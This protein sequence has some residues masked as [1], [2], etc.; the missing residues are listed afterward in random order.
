MTVKVACGIVLALAVIS[1]GGMANAEG[2]RYPCAPSLEDGFRNPPETAAL[3]CWWH[4][5]D[6]CVTREG[7]TRDLEAMADAGISTAHIF[8]PK[9][10]DLPATAPVMSS[11]WIDLFAF[12]IKEAKRTGVKLGFHNCPGWSS[13]GGPW[14][15]PENSMKNVVASAMDV[16]LSAL[17]QDGEIKLP[18]PIS[19]CGFYRDLMTFAF[20]VKKQPKIKSGKVP[21]V[22]P[23]LK[24]DQ[25]TYELEYAEASSPTTAAL[26]V[27]TPNFYM[28]VSVEA[29]VDGRW[30]PRGERSFKCFKANENIKAI[31]LAKGPP[32]ARWRFVFRHLKAPPWVWRK[33]IPIR[34][35]ELG[36]WPFAESGC[37]SISQK[38]IVR[39][40]K[41]A[42]EVSVRTLKKQLSAQRSDS[43]R[44]VRIG[45]TTT[46][47]G[48][49]PASVRGLECD[50]LSRH[51]IE[52]HWGAMPAKLL[53]LPGAKDVVK[54]VV[55][56]SY[57]VGGQNWTQDLPVEFRRR[58]GRALGNFL[59]A[60]VGYS[61]GSPRETEAFNADL[62]DVLR[63]LFA[64]NYFDRFCA[65]CHEAGVQAVLEPYWGPFDI[66]R[67]SRDGDVLTGEF[68]I[69]RPLDDNLRP[70]V[71]AARHHGKNLIAAEAFTTEAKEGRWQ[72]TP[73]QL[74]RVGDAA[75][76]RGVNQFVLHSY[77]HQPYVDRRPGTSLQRH[78]TQLNVNTTWWPEMHVWTDYVKR[79]QF[80]LQYG[81]I[82]RDCHELAGGRLEALVRRGRGGE[83][84][85]FVRN[86]TKEPF[87]GM[88]KLDGRPGCVFD[89]VT[90]LIHPAETR[91][92]ETHVRFRPEESA[93]FV[94]GTETKT[95][96]R[97][98]AGEIVADLSKDWRIVSFDG[99]DAPTAPIQMD[100]LTSWHLS[101]NAQL[102]YFSGRA[103]YLK[104]G[105]FP[106]GMLDLGD[107]RE[108]AVVSVDGRRIGTLW[109]KPYQ[110][111][112]PAGHRIEVEVIN[113]WPNRLIGDAIRVRNG[114]CPFTWSN[115]NGGWTADDALRPAGLLGPVSLKSV[116]DS[117]ADWKLE[118]FARRN[119]NLLEVN[120]PKGESG[121]SA[122]RK[123]DLSRL[124][125]EVEF[126]IR[127]RGE[128]VTKP[129]KKW[130]GSKFML[131][132]VDAEGKH[133]WPGAAQKSGTF[134]WCELRFVCDFGTRVI[135]RTGELT[136]GLQSASGKIVFDLDSFRIIKRDRRLWQRSIAEVG[137]KCPY[138]STVSEKPRKR[139][140]MLPSGFCKED[141]FRTL[142][143]WGATLVRYQ[144]CR[145]WSKEGDNC[146]L[147][148]YDRWLD[149]KLNHLD[150]EVLPWAEKYGFEVAVDLHVA[151]GGRTGG[152][153]NMFY[154]KAYGDHFIACWQKIARR[155]KGRKNIYGYDLIN[156]PNQQFTGVTD[157]DCWNLQRRA[158]EAVR[159]I[160]PTVTI[161]LE[162]NGWDSPKAYSYMRPLRMTNVVY[163]AHMYEPSQFTHQ[164]VS[165]RNH[166]VKARYP[167]ETKGW[168][169][170]YLRR[171][172]EEVR[173]FQ[174]D[175]NAKIYIGEFSAIAWAEGADTYLRD[176]ISLFEEYG[177]DW[178]YHAFR[179]WDGWS[180]EHEG[181][182]M[183][184]LTPSGD[185]PRRQALIDGLHSGAINLVTHHE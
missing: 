136:F 171:Q 183:D 160:D 61:V 66:T 98:Q 146:D 13:S 142:R 33:D 31:S 14:I 172:L 29:F 84:I 153:M 137:Y 47:A 37:G 118:R 167:D 62:R 134:D 4:W 122:M 129:E 90:G 65:L 70:V 106:S 56:D 38:D 41:G 68:W 147:A 100:A 78:G 105:N 71:E 102:R 110:I 126:S 24:N 107:V 116:V 155:F 21:S 101:D 1:P 53:S 26:D 164:G 27:A 138:S 152:E 64:E 87:D 121:C 144:M 130:L 49:S 114:E 103:R 120:V 17:P 45:Y 182:D 149:A 42:S 128:N 143:E 44:I 20:P 51:G 92:E 36:D 19:K 34:C 173:K 99:L 168:D 148:E 170:D 157:G 52:A 127:C 55:I 9:M 43:W 22:V 151:P 175:H 3:Q 25:L 123:I 159:A 12:A 79:G 97:Q 82:E 176:C 89:A 6:D 58:K 109:Q 32:A 177:W 46:G 104:E 16:E 145:N 117:E 11:A 57:E 140:V 181:P 135:G 115:W 73:D 161:I 80:L 85:V 15:T 165:G 96:S 75:W 39:I 184:H 185:N 81:T 131:H 7:I 69:G 158:A 67:C 23:L 77:L 48:P 5:I 94:F 141:D 124:S 108:L 86:R 30:I 91:G 113:T 132:Y 179:E 166:W 60:M 54:F 119:G 162:S 50:K 74:R 72:I 59:L 28:T 8:A 133:Q 83:R 180:V 93:F 112:V 10:T 18:E 76:V 63:T 40:G 169:K 156:E 139:G 150:Q 125:G 154:E 111:V 178:S 174:L 95:V 88:V 2:I 163:Q 35:A